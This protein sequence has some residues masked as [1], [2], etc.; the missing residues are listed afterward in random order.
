MRNK[1]QDM[2]R[3]NAAYDL[4][5]RG[6]S[7]R[8]IGRELG[9]GHGTAQRW[10]QE[11]CDLVVLPNVEAVRKQEVDRLMRYL[12]RL[13]ARVEEGDDRAIS[14]AIKISERLTKMLGVDMPTVTVVEN[15]EVSELDLDIR[16]LI[17]AQNAANAAEKRRAAAK[18]L[19][20]GTGEGE[21][22][23]A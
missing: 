20:S 7:Y 13:D 16:R 5:L 22:E 23:Q 19:S 15:H 17:E 12:D 4:R 21:R 2:E 18:E 1:E 9:I 6:K 8:E 14:L 11:V 10:V 3:K